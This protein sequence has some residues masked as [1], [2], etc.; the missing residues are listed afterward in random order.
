MEHVRRKDQ[1]NRMRRVDAIRRRLQFSHNRNCGLLSF[2]GDNVDFARDLAKDGARGAS[3]AL[4]RELVFLVMPR[5]QLSPAFVKSAA[6]PDGLKKVDFYDCEQRGF[7]LEVRCS[8]GKTFYQR[9]TDDRG[10]ER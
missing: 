2:R 9:Y 7:L 10:R 3:M 4:N 8:G 5:V 1:A 6:C